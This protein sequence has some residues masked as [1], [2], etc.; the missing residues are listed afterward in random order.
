MNKILPASTSQAYC[1]AEMRKKSTDWPVSEIDDDQWWYKNSLYNS[2][3]NHI[4]LSEG[5]GQ[6]FLFMLSCSWDPLWKKMKSWL[7][8]LKYHMPVIYCIGCLL[9]E[10]VM[11]NI[12]QQ[13]WNLNFSTRTATAF[14]YV[15]C[16]SLFQ[17][18]KCI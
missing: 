3:L 14:I 13:S 12:F 4:N 18:F 7:M 8:S 17:S 15:T 5:K 6:R 9:L 1:T 16:L 2:Y 11:K 10:K